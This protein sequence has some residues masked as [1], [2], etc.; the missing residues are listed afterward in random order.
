MIKSICCA[1]LLCA[2]LATTAIAAES[3]E[4]R[5]YQT[6]EGGVVLLGMQRADVLKLMRVPKSRK[7]LP[8]EGAS[9]IPVEEWH[10]AINKD[11]VTL[12]FTGDI[13][14]RMLVSRE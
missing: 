13:L 2:S 1:L 3:W 10:Y 6:A 5:Q 4:T 14:T 7:S 8:A 11:A 9:K 12:T